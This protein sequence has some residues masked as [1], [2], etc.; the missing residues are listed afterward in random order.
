MRYSYLLVFLLLTAC[1][2]NGADRIVGK[3]RQMAFF[4]SAAGGGCNCWKSVHPAKSGKF[5]FKDNLTYF[6]D[7]SALGAASCTGMYRLEKGML[8]MKSSCA[9]N[10]SSTYEWKASVSKNILQLEF[11]LP[12]GPVGIKYVRVK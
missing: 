4:E 1:E 5:E 11:D 2:R 9:S 6:E 8:Y 10:A 7:R 3:W 12:N